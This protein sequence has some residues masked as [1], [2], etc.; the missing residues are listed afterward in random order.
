MNLGPKLNLFEISSNKSE[1][2]ELPEKSPSAPSS[3]R[4]LSPISVKITP[5]PGKNRVDIIPKQDR[6]IVKDNSK[7][8]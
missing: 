3:P 5:E 8:R 2:V 1:K 4:P 6:G 7:N